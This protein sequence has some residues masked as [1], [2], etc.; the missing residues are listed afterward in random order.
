MTTET[1][2]K[3]QKLTGGAKFAVD[4]GPLAVF[5]IAYFLGRR[6]APMV[7]GL[8][9][10]DWTIAEGEEMYLAIGLFMPAFLVAFIYS[11]WK[12]RRV[13]PMLLVS[14]VIISV[15]GGLTLLLH[16]KMFFYMK[17]TLIYALFSALLIGGMATGQNF[18][19]TLFD[20]ALHMPDDAWRTLTKR[21]AIFF[22]ALA[23]LNE[24]AWRWLTRD[25]DLSGAAACAGEKHWVNLKVFGF[26]II[27]LVFTG[28]QAPFLAKHM[29]EDAK[30]GS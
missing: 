5:M 10:Q 2:A 26:T 17:P 23:I 15:F 3:G 13:A 21:Y 28:F 27:S 19:K 1:Q 25:C 14:G 11:V 7:G 22:I 29:P 9:G 18:L 12:E 30:S 8:F 6:L 4:M 20:G 24:V 16:N